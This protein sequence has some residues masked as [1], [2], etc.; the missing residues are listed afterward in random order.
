MRDA[1]IPE[2]RGASGK[3]VQQERL[4]PREVASLCRGAPAEGHPEVQAR[5]MGVT[6]V[7]TKAQLFSPAVLFKIFILAVLNYVMNT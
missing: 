5:N 2:G 7:K 3:S 4:A 6:T 1:G